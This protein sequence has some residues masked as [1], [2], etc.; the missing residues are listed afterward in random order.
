MVFDVCFWLSPLRKSITHSESVK[1]RS[2]CFHVCPIGFAVFARD[3]LIPVTSKWNERKY[4]VILLLLPPTK[5]FLRMTLLLYVNGQA[6][7]QQHRA[8]ICGFY[9]PLTPHVIHPL[10]T[11]NMFR[12]SHL[13]ITSRR[14]R[15]RNQ[16]EG[17]AIECQ[18]MNWEMTGGFS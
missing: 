18:L 17:R 14:S 8:C 2:V 7:H 16:A 10:A 15:C 12:S 4:L 13:F 1:G 6:G 3:Q 9:Y 11:F 5:N